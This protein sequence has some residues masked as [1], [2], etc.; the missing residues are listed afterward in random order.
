MTTQTMIMPSH[1]ISQLAAM[2]RKDWKNMNYAAKPY[3][4]AMEKLDSLDD[5]YYEDS[6]RGIVLYFLANAVSWRGD[7]ARAVKAE[8]KRRLKNN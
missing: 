3:L 5:K 7:V 2:V 1:S 8:L 6:A 4:E